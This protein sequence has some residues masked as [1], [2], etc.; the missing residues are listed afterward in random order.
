MT[1]N[2]KYKQILQTEKDLE[3]KTNKGENTHSKG[4]ITQMAFWKLLQKQRQSSCKYVYIENKNM[5]AF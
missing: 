3:I 2:I 5:Q 1:K 4:T